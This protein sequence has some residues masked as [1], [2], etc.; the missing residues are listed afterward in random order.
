M[1][2][3]RLVTLRLS[4]DVLSA[5]SGMARMDGRAPAD[6]I[7]DALANA[8]AARKG[9]SDRIPAEVGEAFRAAPEWLTLQSRLRRLGFVLRL[10]A[11]GHLALFSWPHER[12]IVPV[13][14]I[15]H[16]QTTLS[17]RFHAPFPAG[18][19]GKPTRCDFQ[20]DAV[21]ARLRSAAAGDEKAA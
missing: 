1:A 2:Q 11:D 3:E 20:M 15:G 13:E 18:M 12:M 19:T 8:L 21:V 4:D 6:I 16:T 9:G 14:R 5:L 17:L 10:D 7:R